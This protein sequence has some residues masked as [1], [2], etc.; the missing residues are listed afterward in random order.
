MNWTGMR[1][2]REFCAVGGKHMAQNLLLPALR[3]SAPDVIDAFIQYAGRTSLEALSLRLA[4]ARGIT[5]RL[6]K[7][8]VGLEL[9]EWTY[10]QRSE[11][12][13][14][15]KSLERVRELAPDRSLGETMEEAQIDP[16]QLPF[17]TDD[18]RGAALRLLRMPRD[19]VQ[20]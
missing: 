11:R 17:K 20:C 15:F 7:R 9:P 16:K 2:Y 6:R 13:F 4:L 10:R 8:Q 18:V 12:L 1:L 14:C 3:C 5:Q 19:G